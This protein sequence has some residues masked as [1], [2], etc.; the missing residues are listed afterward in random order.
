MIFHE[1]TQLTQII[2][3]YTQLFIEQM[4]TLEEHIQFL[5]RMCR[6][7]GERVQD[8]EKHAKGYS[9]KLCRNY[10]EKICKTFGVN[11][12][13]DIEGQHPTHICHKC[14]KKLYRDKRWEPVQWRSHPRTGSCEVCTRW[15]Q[16]SK[17]GHP[18]KRKY[19]HPPDHQP[20]DIPFSKLSPGPKAPT[21]ESHFQLEIPDELRCGFCASL[22]DEALESSCG[23]LF[24][25]QCT[26]REYEKKRTSTCNICNQKFSMNKMVSPKEYLHRLMNSLLPVKCTKC[27][28]TMPIKDVQNHTCLEDEAMEILSHPLEEPLTPLMEAIGSH[29][30]KSKLAQSADGITASFQT[31]GQVK[32]Y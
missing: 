5:E 8:R 17:G 2:N 29:I 9:P 10:C 30:V 32:Q 25:L 26:K 6:L 1:H 19:N 21:L 23:H 11:L 22:S 13:E 27:K 24:C 18:K 7:C 12:D 31:R 20:C 3:L 28:S 4:A 16:Q 15:E 14:H